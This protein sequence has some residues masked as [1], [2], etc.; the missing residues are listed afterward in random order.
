VFTAFHALLPLA[1]VPW[2]F[3]WTGLALIP[4]GNFVF[5]STG[6][7]LCYH[8]TLT[9]QGL[10]LPKWLEHFFALLGLCCLMESPA[11]WVAI[12]R[13]HHKFSDEEP[14]PHTPLAGFFW[15]HVEWLV[16]PNRDTSTAEMYDRYAKDIL[17]DPFYMR[18]E[19]GGMWWWV[20][21]VHAVLFLVAGV[22]A[23][24]WWTGRYMGGVQLGLS[25]VL[26][27]VIYRTIFTWHITWAVN[28][29]AHVWGYRNYSTTD[30]SRN[31]WLVALATNG[32]GWHNNH[33][34][35]QVACSHGHRWWE[36]DVT[37][38]TIRFL[39][40]VGLAKNVKRPR[41]MTVSSDGD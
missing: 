20:Y 40:M 8:R 2:L 29:V 30:S 18:L 19:R 6:I 41:S 14:D 24:W 38:M 7:G 4:I 32:E 39:E 5:C 23:G 22:A 31:N 16:R 10:T 36:I 28:S 27:G 13:M 35:D 26:W 34:A 33:H 1:A 37:Y 21:V 12:H 15:G 25:I 11:R 17:R 9:H 3:S